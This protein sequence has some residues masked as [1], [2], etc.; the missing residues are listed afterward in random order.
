MRDVTYDEDRSQIRAGTG[1]QV[2]AALRNAAIGARASGVTNIAAATS[3]TAADHWP[4]SASPNDFARG[5]ANVSFRILPFT[6]PAG[7]ALG[8]SFSV[9]KFSE[10]AMEDVVSVEGPLGT[11]FQT[12]ASTL[13]VVS[14]CSMI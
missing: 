13:S 3:P 6:A 12:K 7:A 2:M 1:P 5:P 14:A 4:Y 8:G 11:I 10:P 9:W